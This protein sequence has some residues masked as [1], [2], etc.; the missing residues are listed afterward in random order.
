MIR[1]GVAGI[2]LCGAGLAGW[3]ASRAMLA[4]NAPFVPAD[5]A[6]PAPTLLS[7]T[8]RRRAGPVTRLALTVAQEASAMS[9]LDPASLRSVFAS[10]NG[11]G[12]VVGGIL[13]ALSRPDGFVSPTQFH[14]SVHNAAAGYWSIGVASAQPATVLGCHDWSFAAGLLKAAAEAVA[15]HAPVLLAVYDVPLTPPMSGKR[16][17]ASAFGVA[18]V[19]VPDA[20][21]HPA[22]D[23]AFDCE[24]SADSAPDLASLAALANTNPAAR[25][26]CLLQALARNAARDLTLSYLD[27]HLAARLSPCS[28]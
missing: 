9:G 16:P 10:S 22:L 15:E 14:N 21:G 4:G 26:L 1:V 2:G 27:G 17:M 3:H 20:T 8:E 23:V 6:L 24:P 12:L 11:D 13:D 5:I 28:T 19:L 7:P 25:S 18:L